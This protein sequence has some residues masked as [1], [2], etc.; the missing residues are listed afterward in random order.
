MCLRTSLQDVT[1]TIAVKIW[2]AACYELF[3]VIATGLRELWEKKGHDNEDKQEEIQNGI[4]RKKY[5]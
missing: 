5:C 1:G 3:G 4:S 2:D